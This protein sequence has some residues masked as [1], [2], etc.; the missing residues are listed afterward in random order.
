VQK[1]KRKTQKFKQGAAHVKV[2]CGD[3]KEAKEIA[4]TIK[5]SISKSCPGQKSRSSLQLL[6]NVRELQST[7]KR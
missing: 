7:L 5:E 6:K 1:L 2:K 4:V 3:Q